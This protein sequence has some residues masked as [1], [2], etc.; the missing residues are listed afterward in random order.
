MFS[1]GESAFYTIQRGIWDG[2]GFEVVHD[3][4]VHEG[5]IQPVIFV[6][7]SLAREMYFFMV[8]ACGD[9]QDAPNSTYFG[10]RSWF[11]RT[12]HAGGLQRR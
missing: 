10:D 11:S 4:L 5:L 12:G 9:F 3:Q 1:D 2:V 7:M 8:Q 6:A